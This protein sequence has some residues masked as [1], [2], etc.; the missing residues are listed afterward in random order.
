MHNFSLLRFKIFDRIILKQ[1][2]KEG[3]FSGQQ[4]PGYDG[5]A[6]RTILFSISCISKCGGKMKGGNFHLGF[7]LICKGQSLTNV[8]SSLQCLSKFTGL[9]VGK[10]H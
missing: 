4:I 10:A 1:E 5:V 8:H 7:L 3:H 2:G 6:H 9:F